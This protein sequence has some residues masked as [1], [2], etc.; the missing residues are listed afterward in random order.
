MTF[1]HFFSNGQ[2][3][4]VSFDMSATPP[5]CT[6]TPV[7]EGCEEEYRVWRHNVVMT[8]VLAECNRKQIEALARKGEDV[9]RGDT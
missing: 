9:V 1:H 4:T 6:A 2:P 3:I 5:K 8:H 7:P